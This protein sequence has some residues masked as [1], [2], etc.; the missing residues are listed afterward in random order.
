MRMDKLASS[1]NDEFYTPEYA[2][3]PL[4]DHIPSD[5]PVVWCPF[6]TPNSSIVRMLE[7]HGAWCVSTHIDSGDDFFNTEPPEGCQYI[8]PNPP[9]S[10]KTKVFERLFSLGIPFA[11]L[12][13]MVGVFEGPRFR[14]FKGR[15]TEILWMSKR[16]S[17]FKDFTDKKPSVN[18][19]FSS[20]WVCS[21]VLPAGNIFTEITKK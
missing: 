21:N 7:A 17:Y 13:G 3:Y 12:V 14:I 9:Y 11:M 2:V 1:Q 20:A 5:G 15:K 10:M 19:P 16:V 8:I 4:L 6:D 18:P